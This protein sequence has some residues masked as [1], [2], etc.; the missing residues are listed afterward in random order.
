VGTAL[1]NCLAAEEG[2]RRNALCRS[3]AA[4]DQGRA[5]RNAA[6]A[7]GTGGGARSCRRGSG[8]VAPAQLDEH[9]APAVQLGDRVKRGNDWMWG[10]QDVFA[11]GLDDHG[12]VTGRGAQSE[13]WCKVKWDNGLSYSYRVG[14]DGAHDLCLV[15]S[16]TKTPQRDT[17]KPSPGKL[18]QM[19]SSDD[20]NDNGCSETVSTAWFHGPALSSSILLIILGVCGFVLVSGLVAMCCFRNRKRKI[21]AGMKTVLFLIFFLFD[22]VWMGARFHWLLNSEDAQFRTMMTP[23]NGEYIWISPKFTGSSWSQRHQLGCNFSLSELKEASDDACK[24]W[25]VTF[26][27]DLSFQGSSLDAGA[28]KFSVGFGLLI[29]AVLEIAVFFFV[30]GTELKDMEEETLDLPAGR[31]STCTRSRVRASVYFTKVY[32]VWICLA[33]SIQTRLSRQSPI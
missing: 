31:L 4:I 15:S 23:K 3:A 19:C 11:Q 26:S 8:D 1:L 27:A 16:S 6:V 25:W 28:A 9:H 14:W 7:S 29:F 32:L 2:A 20:N 12:T 17:A 24:V 18:Q 21:T 30:L 13:L 22:F 5:S 33:W 10:S